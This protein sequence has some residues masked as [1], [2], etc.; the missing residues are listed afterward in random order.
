MKILITNSNLASNTPPN[1]SGDQPNSLCSMWKGVELHIRVPIISVVFA[2]LGRL[3]N[4]AH[5]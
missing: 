5:L 1:F 3:G 2:T 4:N